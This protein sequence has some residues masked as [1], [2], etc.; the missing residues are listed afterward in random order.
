MSPKSHWLYTT[1]LLQVDEA[2]YA[3]GRELTDG[4]VFAI[5]VNAARDGTLKRL[6]MQPLPAAT[7]GQGTLETETTGGK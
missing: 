7:K 3:R 1:L 5:I 2:T 6:G 4:E